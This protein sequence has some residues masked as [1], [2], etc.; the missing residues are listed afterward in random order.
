MGKGLDQNLFGQSGA[1]PQAGIAN[2]ANQAA[3]AA[4]EP[5]FLLFAK[6][7]LAQAVGHLRRSGQLFDAHGHARADTAQRAEEWLRTMPVILILRRSRLFHSKNLGF[8]GLSCKK[9]EGHL[10]AA[11]LE[12]ES[13]PDVAIP[14]APC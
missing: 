7:H 14:A 4:Q 10:A 6:A 11:R 8:L 3:L 12:A 5:Y 9:E 1:D 2:L 13:K